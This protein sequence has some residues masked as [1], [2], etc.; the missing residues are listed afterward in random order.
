MGM[1]GL[2]LASA[3]AS[4]AADSAMAWLLATAVVCAAGTDEVVTVPVG[5]VTSGGMAAAVP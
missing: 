3:V 2:A 5:F 1:E 4:E